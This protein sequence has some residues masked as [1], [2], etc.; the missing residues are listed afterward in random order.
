MAAI[1]ETTLNS[2]NKSNH[3][4][5]EIMNGNLEEHRRN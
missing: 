1:M 4:G 2:C 3:T 5:K